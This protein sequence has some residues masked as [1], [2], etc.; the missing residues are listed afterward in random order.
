MVCEGQQGD[1]LA[2]TEELVGGWLMMV[3]TVDLREVV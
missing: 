2:R 1:P 3:S